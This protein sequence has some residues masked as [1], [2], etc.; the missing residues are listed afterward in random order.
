[1]KNIVR[2]LNGVP[3]LVISHKAINLE[4]PSNISVGQV[5]ERTETKLQPKEFDLKVIEKLKEKMNLSQKRE[6]KVYRRKK[7]KGPNPL[8]CLKKKRK[9]LAN[10]KK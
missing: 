1:M 4:K 2:K 7:V 6:E 5:V 3:L 10:N 9:I 8:S